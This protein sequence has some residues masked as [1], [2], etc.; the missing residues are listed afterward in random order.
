MWAGES[1]GRYSARLNRT[2]ISPPAGLDLAR[3]ARSLLL[4]SAGRYLGRER[5]RLRREGS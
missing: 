3:S 5:G 1:E 2:A 4:L